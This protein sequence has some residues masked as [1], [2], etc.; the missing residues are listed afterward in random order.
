MSKDDI[1]QRILAIL[2]HTFEIDVT[3]VSLQSRLYED[4]EIDSIDAIDLLVQLK[5]VVGK[6]LEPESFKS[7]RTLSDVVE[8]LHALLG[9]AT[10]A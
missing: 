6:R 2:E 5:P 8:A 9:D 4:L 10:P 7:V 1:Y 3:S